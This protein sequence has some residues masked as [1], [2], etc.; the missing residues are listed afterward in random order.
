MIGVPPGLGK[1]S[2]ALI[3]A[4][5]AAVPFFTVVLGLYQITGIFT[6]R[7]LMALIRRK[8]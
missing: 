8:Q 4:A 7:Q 6:A 1:T 3:V 2:N 5:A